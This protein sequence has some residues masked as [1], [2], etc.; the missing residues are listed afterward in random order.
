MRKVAAHPPRC[1]M[2]GQPV[3]GGHVRESLVRRVSVLIVR[4]LQPIRPWVRVLR[5][6]NGILDGRFKWLVVRREGAI[7][8][9]ARDVEPAKTFWMHD[10]RFVAAKCLVASGVFRRT[11]IRS[12]GYREVWDIKASPFALLLVPPD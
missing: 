9:S 4:A 6:I 11:I 7:F 3:R 12:L 5:G 2:L 8:K 10:E 1:V